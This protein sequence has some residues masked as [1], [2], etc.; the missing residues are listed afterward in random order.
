MA[1]IT[2][3]TFERGEINTLRSALCY[4]RQK[5]SKKNALGSDD[6]GECIRLGYLQH[7][8]SLLKALAELEKK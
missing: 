1:K 2:N 8:N 5:M 7:S 6:I 3:E 4:F